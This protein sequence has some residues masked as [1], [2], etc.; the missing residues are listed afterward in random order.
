MKEMNNSSNDEFKGNFN[1]ANILDKNEK[2]IAK[3][4]ISSLLQSTTQTVVDSNENDI[5]ENFNNKD[6][7]YKKI[8]QLE[9]RFETKEVNEKFERL[10]S[11]LQSVIINQKSVK[12]QIEF[13]SEATPAPAPVIKE[14]KN[15]LIASGVLSASLLLSAFIYT[16]NTAPVKAKPVIQEVV[17]PKVV[18]KVFHTPVKYLNLRSI[19]S[20]K[21]QKLQV[22]APN[23]RVE[24]I[25]KDGDWI[26]IEYRDYLKNTLHSGWVYD[27]KNLKSI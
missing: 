2:K 3:S 1:F 27:E 7:L 4:P 23:T 19:P 6:Q 22:V 17:A 24:I 21:G 8:E 26:Q 20:T 13:K 16:P 14:N 18:A 11:L 12:E 5:Q 10:E 15:I 9:R 25:K